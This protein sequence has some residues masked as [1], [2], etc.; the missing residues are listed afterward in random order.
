MEP[1]VRRGR[2]SVPMMCGDVF[3]HTLSSVDGIIVKGSKHVSLWVCKLKS[4]GNRWYVR[5]VVFGGMTWCSYGS[6]HMERDSGSDLSNR[7]R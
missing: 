1:V 2:D 6:K 7:G 3:A 5:S 4:H